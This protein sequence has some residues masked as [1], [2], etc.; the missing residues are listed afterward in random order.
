MG[1]CCAMERPGSNGGQSYLFEMHHYTTR[2]HSALL[3]RSR[4][5]RRDGSPCATMAV[6]GGPEILRVSF[7]L[8]QSPIRDVL[9]YYG[10]MRVATRLSSFVVPIIRNLRMENGGESCLLLSPLHLILN[11]L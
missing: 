2:H 1:Q 4:A 7:Y 5:H 9:G 3:A 8:H 11:H 10:A 6:D